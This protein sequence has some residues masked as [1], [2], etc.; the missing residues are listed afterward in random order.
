MIRD[1]GVKGDTQYF[2][3]IEVEQTLAFGKKTLFVNGMLDPQEVV[4]IATSKG[5]DHVYLGAN[6]SFWLDNKDAS[7]VATPEQFR[8]WNNL[9]TTLREAGL[10][11]TLDYDVKYH[12]WVLEQG[13]NEYNRFISMISVKLPHIDALNYNACLKVDDKD[14]D[15]T[16]SGVWVHSVHTLKD[17]TAYTDWSKYKNDK[18]I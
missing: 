5:I 17:Q 4:T 13:F 10:W 1:N 8:G 16:N 14:F 18:G 12:S 15:A 7:G 11:I 9:F 2:T 3:G 6:Q